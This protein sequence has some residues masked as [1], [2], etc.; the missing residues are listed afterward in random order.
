[1]LRVAANATH[2]AIVRV[3]GSVRLSQWSEPEPDLVLLA[4]SA[5]FY[6]SELASGTDAL[7]VIEISDSTL[8]YDRDRKVPLY[9]RH[10]VPEVWIV[11]VAGNA[12]LVY[13][14]LRDG[15][16][17]RHAVLDRPD[18]VTLEQLPGITLDLA[19]LFVS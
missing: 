5:D 3:Q 2:R 10:G 14:A 8:R 17:E 4:P 13:G 9:A 18:R 6:R 19:A 11:D 7:L 1:M 16:Y 12:L 15:Q